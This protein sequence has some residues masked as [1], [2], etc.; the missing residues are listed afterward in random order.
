MLAAGD[1]PTRSFGAGGAD[2]WLIKTDSYGNE[3]WNKTY[4]TEGDEHFWEVHETLDNGYIMIG[5]AEE[6]RRD[7]WVVKT[8]SDGNIDWDKKF[9]PANQGLS[10][11]QCSDGG[12][13]FLAEVEDTVFGGYLNAWMV[14]ID[15]D[16]IEEWNKLFIT[17]IGE[18][19]FAVHHNIKSLSDGG[20]ILTGVTNAVTPVYSVGDMWISKIDGNGNI[21]WEKII[22][23]SGYDTTYTVDP[24]SDGGFIVSGMTKSYGLGRNFNAWLIKIKD[25]EN[26]RPNKPTQPDGPSG[27]KPGKEYTFSTS[28][29][30]PEGEQLFYIWDWGDDNF[31]DWLDTNKATY[32]WS[33]DG[34]FEIRVKAKDIHGGESEWSDPLSMS[35]QKSKVRSPFWYVFL[36]EY[37]PLFP[38]IKFLL[39]VKGEYK[40]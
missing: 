36:K 10:I 40:T 18:D 23:G 4:G 12:Y 2:G 14:K 29:T 39:N 3:Q 6:A 5:F 19:N 16:G 1:G 15:E 22:G 34:T 32:A 11:T 31:S 30:D 24:T 27:G 38:V 25:F 17:P 37:L 26:T 20:Y 33:Y 9:G 35:I 8:D 21:L 28:T 7:A 13:I